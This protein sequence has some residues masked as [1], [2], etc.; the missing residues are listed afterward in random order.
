MIVKKNSNFNSS[1]F[2]L[3][4]L[5]D[6]SFL[7]VEK[8]IKKN[9]RYL[10]SFIKIKSNEKFFSFGLL[11]SLHL[12]KSLKQYIRL[13]KFFSL[14]KRKHIYLSSEFNSFFLVKLLL[15]K[16]ILTKD[17]TLQVEKQNK[18]NFVKI[19]KSHFN[20][21][22]LLIALNLSLNSN[23]NNLDTLVSNNLFLINEINSNI[24]TKNDSFYKIFNETSDFKKII[25]LL[26]LLDKH[27][28]V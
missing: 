20:H 1:I 26:L 4:E 2:K 14:K 24:K 19:K 28:K 8:K 12:I 23:K 21:C 27:L 15:N 13:V 7:K 5:S 3:M 18:V 16:L 10:D 17:I 22:K 6:F 11:D 9:S 25:F